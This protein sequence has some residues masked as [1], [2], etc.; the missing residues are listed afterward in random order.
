VNDDQRQRAEAFASIGAT[1]RE[2]ITDALLDHVN[3]LNL[4]DRR[5]ATMIVH[6][7]MRQCRALKR[8]RTRTPKDG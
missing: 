3:S 6:Y 4:E 7:F 5:G 1:E 2:V 8:A